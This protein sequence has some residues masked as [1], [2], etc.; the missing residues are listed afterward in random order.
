LKRK[1]DSGVESWPRVRLEIRDGFYKGFFRNEEEFPLA[2][3]QFKS[4]Y[5]DAK[6]RS[7]VTKIPSQE[8]TSKYDSLASGPGKHRVEFDI[9]FD[10]ETEITGYMSAKLFMES[11]KSDDMHVFVTLWKLDNERQ[12]VGMTYY[13]QVCPS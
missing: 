11:P 7:L 3:T 1:T 8:S 13:A 10:E 6:S 9:E 5:L 4:L 12:P 2:R